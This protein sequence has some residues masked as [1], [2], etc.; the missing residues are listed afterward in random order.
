MKSLADLMLE[1]DNQGLK[2]IESLAATTRL[3]MKLAAV[4]SLGSSLG[5]DKATQFADGTANLVTDREFLGELESEIG[6]PGP[7]ETE[8]EFV[9]RAKS[10][11]FEMLKSK[12]S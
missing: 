1:S 8:D 10:A 12:L 6:M 7:N 3:N 11:M 9:A 2:K 4:A 5:N